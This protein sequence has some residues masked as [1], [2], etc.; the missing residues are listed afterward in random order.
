MIPEDTSGYEAYPL[1]I[2]MAKTHKDLCC[3]VEISPESVVIRSPECGLTVKE[4]AA[5]CRECLSFASI[6]RHRLDGIES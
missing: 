6:N 3:P 2:H 4:K 1:M 5:T